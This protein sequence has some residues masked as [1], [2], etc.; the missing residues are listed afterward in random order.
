MIASIIIT[1]LYSNN[2]ILFLVIENF[3]NTKLTE[4][5]TNF[6]PIFQTFN[7]TISSLKHN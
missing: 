3:R 5:K 1:D 2:K 6:Q 4:D 7:S